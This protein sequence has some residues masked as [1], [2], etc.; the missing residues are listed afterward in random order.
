MNYKQKLANFTNGLDGLWYL[1]ALLQ[2]ALALQHSK[3][4]LILID[5]ITFGRI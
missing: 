1:L 4:S 5:K 3:I 2:T